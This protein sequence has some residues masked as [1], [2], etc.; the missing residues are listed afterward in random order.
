MKGTPLAMRKSVK[1][2]KHSRYQGKRFPKSGCPGCLELY[3]EEIRKGG[4]S[5]YLVSWW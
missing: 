4:M 1:C 2:K 5:A 3:Y